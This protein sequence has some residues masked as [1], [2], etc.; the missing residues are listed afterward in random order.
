MV[1]FGA[2]KAQRT[3]FLGLPTV[4]LVLFSAPAIR[5]V[6]ECPEKLFYESRED[7][8]LRFR[9]NPAD[10][11]EDREAFDA[12]V[13]TIEA[14][15]PD[16]EN[17]K[18]TL[19]DSAKALTGTL[20]A[21]YELQRMALEPYFF[22]AIQLHTNASDPA[23]DAML[24]VASALQARALEAYSFVFSEIAGLPKTRLD[25]LLE[26]PSTEPYRHVVDDVV[27]TKS[28]I[29]SPEVEQV[30][31]GAFQ[32]RAGPGGISR[33]LLNGDIVWPT[34]VSPDGEEV[35]VTPGT[36]STFSHSLDRDFRRDGRQALLKTYE[37]Y[38]NTLSA[39]LATHVQ[40]EAWETKV[41]GYNSSL[42]RALD[43]QN[44]PLPV[45][46]SLV[47]SV[48]NNF[49]ITRNYSALRKRALGVETLYSYDLAV[50]LVPDGARRYCFEEAWA[51]AMAFW[52]EIYGER[53]AAV[54]EAAYANRW[55]D[56]FTNEGKVS[57]AYAWAVY[58]KHPYLLLNWQGKFRDVVTLVHEVGHIVHMN[59]T[60]THQPYQYSG[61]SSFVAEVAST[62]SESLFIDWAIQ[63]SNDPHE[64]AIML[65]EAVNLAAGSFIR[66][67][68]FHEFEAAI[69]DDAENGRPLT[70]DT[71]SEIFM[72]LNKDYYGPDLTLN[73]SDG[74]YYLR[75]PHFY[76]NYYVW[77]YATS[78]A[79][80]EAIAARLR[81]GDKGAVNDFFEMLKLGSSVYPMDALRVA[82]VDFEDPSV[83]GEIMFRFKSL[84]EQFETELDQ[85]GA[86]ASIAT[87]AAD[88]EGSSAMA[89]PALLLLALPFII[90]I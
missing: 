43:A 21:G 75:I 19:G 54:A 74:I 11:F 85:L 22:A 89:L 7:I 83:V 59:L 46:R 65:N 39:A 49:D 72:D 64:R 81:T 16:V 10:V 23:A 30:L 6:T 60:N 69:Y 4:A 62:A 67:I 31:A 50:T 2:T 82:G 76:Y 52:R 28:H 90:Y 15:I 86:A 56:V 40:G 9:W 37:A 53:Y 88:D 18:G 5:C 78:Y 13:L 48:H 24:G 71:M 77:V 32:L 34:V 1:A 45:V 55:M 57:G 68:L 41:R 3:F 51:L 17:R 61:T 79:A 36:M 26:D 25:A 14:A 42:E 63:R 20:D 27:R 80:G 8:P 35:Q 73:A 44:V 58:G 66:Q 87:V 33:H 84:I 47:D 29:R 70:K 12:A 38:G